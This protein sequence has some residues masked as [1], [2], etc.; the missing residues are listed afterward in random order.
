[1]VTFNKIL[2]GKYFP[3]SNCFVENGNL[4]TIIPKKIAKLKENVDH[5]FSDLIDIKVKSEY[6][7]VNECDHFTL[8][9]YCLRFSNREISDEEKVHINIMLKSVAKLEKDTPVKVRYTLRGVLE[10]KMELVIHKVFFY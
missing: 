7:W 4:L 9:E 6:G 2:V 3:N 10:R 8:E 1:M 5:V